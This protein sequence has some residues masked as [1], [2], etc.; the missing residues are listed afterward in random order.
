MGRSIWDLKSNIFHIQII[1]YLIDKL[2]EQNH[3]WIEFSAISPV[4]TETTRQQGKLHMSLFYG[5]DQWMWNTRVIARKPHT[6][7]FSIR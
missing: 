4:F 7:E 3:L 5:T 6:L 2:S 1:F